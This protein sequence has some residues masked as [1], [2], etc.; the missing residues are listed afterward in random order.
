MVQK[1]NA[2]EIFNSQHTN[3]LTK[4]KSRIE[5]NLDTGLRH[6]ID[7]ES[8]TAKFHICS[9]TDKL[10]AAGMVSK[11][12]SGHIAVLGCAYITVTESKT[13]TFQVSNRRMW[14]YSHTQRS[15]NW[16]LCYLELVNT[17]Y[18]NLVL[19]SRET[20]QINV[21]YLLNCVALWLFF[22]REAGLAARGGALS[23]F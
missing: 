14:F 21:A 13:T 10:Q 15:R 9:R 11:E 20:E 17:L 7:T 5:K 12:G 1:S 8:T 6:T 16:I 4:Q 18:H 22:V 2:V 3:L 19:V 23:A